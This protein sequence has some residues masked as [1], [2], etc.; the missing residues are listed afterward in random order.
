MVF[1]ILFAFGCSNNDDNNNNNPPVNSVKDI[2]GNIYHYTNIGTQEWMIENLKVTH[3]RNGDQILKI[4]VDSQWQNLTRGAFIDFNNASAN[5]IIYGHLYNF[6]AV[7]D[8]RG[9]CP[10]G[11]HVPTDA[12]WNVL[13]SF[14]GGDSVAASKL[15]EKGTLHWASPNSGVTNVTG[16]TALPGGYRS[17]SGLFINLRNMGYWW[18]ST[19]E[20]SSGGWARNM[21]HFD[22]GVSRTNYLK[23]YGFSV[24]CIKDQ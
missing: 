20:S 6:Y 22:L 4:I 12:E 18:S 9:I 2:D 14:L 17:D 1:F 5:G 19:Q 11:W 13:I 24:R 7:A 15:K 16:F 21:N 23:T 3:Y 10:S 8:A